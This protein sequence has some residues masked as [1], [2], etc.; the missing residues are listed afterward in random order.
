LAAKA[1]P[2]LRAARVLRQDEYTSWRVTLFRNFPRARGPRTSGIRWD[3][4]RSTHDAAGLRSAGACAHYCILGYSKITDFG[5]ALFHSRKKKT[6]TTFFHEK[7]RVPTSKREGKLSNPRGR[8]ERARCMEKIHGNLQKPARRRRARFMH[9]FC[10][11]QVYSTQGRTVRLCVTRAVYLVLHPGFVRISGK[12]RYAGYIWGR[13][14]RVTLRRLFGIRLYRGYPLS[15]ERD[16]LVDEVTN[17]PEPRWA[18]TPRVFFTGK[19][20]YD[21]RYM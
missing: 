10:R 20:S 4:S 13:K 8:A 6:K 7:L 21:I 9:W 15:S 12:P 16:T 18:S 3:A 14:G 5:L 19:Y 2:G 17:H 1:S 11:G